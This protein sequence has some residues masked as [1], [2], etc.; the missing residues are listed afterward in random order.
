GFGRADITPPPGVGLA[1]NGPE[2]KRAT[3]YRLR[4]Y[5]RAL[6]L[7]DG[8][9]ERLALLVADLPQ[10]SANLHRLT[11]QRIVEATGV[12]AD[13]LI[14]AATHTHAGPGHFYAERQ[15][16]QNVSQVVGYDT[17]MVEFLVSRFARALLDAHADLRPARAAWGVTAVWGHT[18]NRSYE[19]F[20]RNKPEWT[21]PAPP[22]AG[23][24][25]LQRAVDPTWTLLRVD[26][27]ARDGSDRVGFRPAG[28]FSVF[29]I[30]G[31]GDA[32]ENDLLDPGIHGIV[33]RSLE[34]HIDSLNGAPPGF[35]SRAVHLMANGTEGDVSPDWP[36]NSRCGPPSLRPPVDPGGPRTPPAPWAWEP[37]AA[38]HLGLCLAAARAY[39]EAAGDTLGRRAA[40]LFDALGDRLN[41][42][43]R[44]TVAF[45]VLRLKGHPA[46]CPHPEAGAATL[47]GAEDG[48]TRLYGWRLFGLFAVGLEEGASAVDPNPTG[49]QRE[50]RVAVGGL[51]R[52]LIVGAHGFPE[53]AQLSA[54]RIGEMLLAA[55][56]AEVTTMAGAGMKRAMRDSART[57]GLRGDSLALIGLA[58]GYISYVTTD[59]EYGAQHYEGGSTLYG[60][61]T[62][63]VLSEELG[64]LVAALGRGGDRSPRAEIEPLTAYPGKSS[65]ILARPDAGPAPD[66]V[67]RTFLELSCAGDTLRASWLDL[68]PG[69]L[70]P[71]HGPVVR[72]EHQVD[73][74]WQTVA[75]DDDPSIEVRALRPPPH[76]RVGYVWEVRWDRRRRPGSFRVVLAA[77]PGLPE[78]A[79]PDC[80][81]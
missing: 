81:A 56:P 23:L 5:A 9:G 18:R 58:N 75:W 52:R 22:P 69:R 7:E 6:L 24:D 62:A 43:V 66:R 78:H 39:V 47:G 27:Q 29:A 44:V 40:R 16:N 63:A 74:A 38:A 65:R 28:A 3:G 2:G 19:A 55:V 13:R 59:A 71:A 79:S 51:Q 11:A 41:G 8:S 14:L 64:A 42:D 33:E 32:P 72:I 45:H 15:Y 46:L 61:R 26:Q 76:G 35:R 68:Y 10:I 21:P 73:R 60:P 36:V 53:V 80:H 17:A 30:H 57:H 37:P 12:G 70:V 34:R 77:R 54:A 50:K 31:T 1:G 67:T 25:P 49:C 48:R 20:S 4:L